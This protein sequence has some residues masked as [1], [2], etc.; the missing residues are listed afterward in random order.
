MA[1]MEDVLDVY[2][3]PPDPR[4]P[5]VCFDEGSKELHG[6]RAKRYAVVAK[7]YDGTSLAAAIAAAMDERN[8]QTA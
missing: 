7:P 1:R 6:E 2:A 5:L 3:R 8:R 4:R